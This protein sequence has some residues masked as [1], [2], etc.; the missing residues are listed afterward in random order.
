MNC[1]SEPSNPVN[2]TIFWK[3]ALNCFIVLAAFKNFANFAKEILLT[4]VQNCKK[5]I[6]F[7]NLRT[8]SQE[9]DLGHWV[10]FGKAVYNLWFI[11]WLLR[12]DM[13]S[14]LF[15]ICYESG[16]SFENSNSSQHRNW[17]FIFRKLSLVITRLE[18][19]KVYMKYLVF[20]IF[21]YFFLKK[22]V[23]VS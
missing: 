17:V 1:G 21:Y 16:K 14:V 11:P 9:G 7:G 8:V 15:S 6:T 3:S 13:I 22:T 2:H 4:P 19:F 23:F 18:M 10:N 12:R 20:E 5:C